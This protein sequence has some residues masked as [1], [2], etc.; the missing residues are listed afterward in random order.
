MNVAL[1]SSGAYIETDWQR[2]LYAH[3]DAFLPCTRSVADIVNCCFGHDSNRRL[4]SWFKS[5]SIG[6]QTRRKEFTK[7]FQ[8]ERKNFDNH[9]LTKVR[10]VTVHRAGHPPIE[11]AFTGFWGVRY[12]SNPTVRLSMNEVKPPDGSNMGWLNQSMPLRPKWEDFQIGGKNLFSA[13]NEYI[14]D[15][16]DLVNKARNIASIVH[17]LNPLSNP[18]A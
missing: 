18:P 13:C 15:A 1:Q 3:F 11:V 14:Q 10:N 17:G 5:L 8:A 16:K 7:Q 6:E 9:L 4:E 12:E 2:H